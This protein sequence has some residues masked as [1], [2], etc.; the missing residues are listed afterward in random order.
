MQHLSS[1]GRTG[2]TSLHQLHV[3]AAQ[4][5]VF[6]TQLAHRYDLTLIAVLALSRINHYL[7]AP[8]T[9]VFVSKVELIYQV[10]LKEC[11]VARIV[12]L[13][14]THHLAH[15][16]FKVLVVDLHTLESVNGLNL[17]H[18]VLLSLDRTE[19]IEDVGR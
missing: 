4:R 9:V 6:I 11:G 12:Y 18:N 15:D 1:G 10:V 17:I 13:N 19:D 5:R 3:A 16:N 7:L 14:L 8:D 2:I